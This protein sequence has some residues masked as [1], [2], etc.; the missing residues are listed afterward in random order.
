M[1]RLKKKKMW[2]SLV[3]F[4]SH[5][6]SCNAKNTVSLKSPFPLHPHF[7]R[8]PAGKSS[9]KLKQYREQ[10]LRRQMKDCEWRSDNW[11]PRLLSILPLIRRTG[12]Q[13]ESGRRKTAGLTQQKD[14]LEAHKQK[15]AHSC[16][17]NGHLVHPKVTC[18]DRLCKSYLFWKLFFHCFINGACR[19]C[20]WRWSRRKACW[21]L[22]WCTLAW[23][24]FTTEPL[25]TVTHALTLTNKS[26]KVLCA[27]MEMQCQFW[28]LMSISVTSP[29]G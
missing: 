12:K 15:N 9:L 21:L 3:C 25:S 22:K 24:V 19:G 4:V 28:C 29:Y 7:P 16:S 11:G 20:C 27:S 1:S 13:W 17:H 5:P 23:A 10:R 14:L 8:D 18:L 26:L 6:L 2:A